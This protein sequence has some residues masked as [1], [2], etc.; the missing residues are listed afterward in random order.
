VKRKMNMP[1]NNRIAGAVKRKMIN[2]P[3][4]HTAG[5]MIACLLGMFSTISV[6]AKPPSV[7]SIPGWEETLHSG[8]WRVYRKIYGTENR[9]QDICGGLVSCRRFLALA[10]AKL[11][12]IRG[13][14]K[15]SRSVP[16]RMG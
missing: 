6:Y 10:S 2:P 3:K 14:G 5:V 4:K 11:P 16:E 13:T 12:L 9:G 1:L 8:D 7:F 15:R